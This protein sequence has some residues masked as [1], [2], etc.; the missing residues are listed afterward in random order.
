MEMAEDSPFKIVR[1]NAKL[2]FA[3]IASATGVSPQAVKQWEDGQTAP[4]R[5]K[6]EALA[7]VLRLSIQDT[8]DMFDNGATRDGIFDQDNILET[9]KRANRV[10]VRG[11]IAAGVWM[12]VTLSDEGGYEQ[13]AVP[14]PP[15]PDYA[16]EAQYDLVVEGTSLNKVAPDGYRV[17]CVDIEASGVSVHDGDLVIIRRLRDGGQLVEM[18]AK[19]VRKTNGRTELWPDSTDQRWQEK[20]VVDDNPERD[21]I[22]IIAKVLYAYRAA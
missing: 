10:K 1:K 18:T 12:D 9:I 7:R 5:N 11:K 14:F 22:E 15:D 21:R 3:K 6:I 8:M 13:M 16:I 2:T 17:R 4:T 20:I 19:R